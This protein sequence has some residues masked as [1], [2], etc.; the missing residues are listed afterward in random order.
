M[1]TSQDEKSLQQKQKRKLDETSM[2]ND[3]QE[4]SLMSKNIDFSDVEIKPR[5][6]IPLRQ[7]MLENF[8]E[9]LLHF[10]RKEL[11]GQTKPAPQEK[12]SFFP[13]LLAMKQS[14]IPKFIYQNEDLRKFDFDAHSDLL[15]VKL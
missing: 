7:N 2:S 5:D 11:Q 8:L 14:E 3:H 15:Q 13:Q 1:H 12:F 4:P 10:C 6:E 9:L